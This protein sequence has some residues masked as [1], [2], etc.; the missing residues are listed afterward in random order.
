LL[1]AGGHQLTT[2]RRVVNFTKQTAQLEDFPC[3]STSINARNAAP[4]K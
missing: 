1:S 2:G 4:L 3:L